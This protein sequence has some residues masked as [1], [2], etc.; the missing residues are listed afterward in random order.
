MSRTHTDKGSGNG[1][2]PAGIATELLRYCRSHD[3]AGYDP[4]DGLNSRVFQSLRFLHFK[5]PRLALIQ[6]LK[7]SPINFR[8]IL[9]VPQEQNPKGL[10]LF[11]TSLIKLS[12]LGLLRDDASIRYL[13][14]RLLSLSNSEN[15]YL[16]WGYHFDW[17]TRKV[18][19]PRGTP[20]IICTTFAANA[21]L[22]AHKH[23]PDSRFL[24]TVLG[25][26][27]FLLERLY[28]K[29]SDS[30][31]CFSY[32]QPNRTFVH[33]ANL[34]GAA[35]VSRV[36]RETANGSLLA[37][38]LEAAR[39]TVNKQ[40][41]DGSWDYGE[42]DHPSQRWIDNFHTG[43]NL[44]ALRAIGL[45]AESSEF[46]PAIRRGFDFFRRHFFEKDGA[47][48]YYHD[49]LYPIDI[50]SAAQSI[51]T[52]VTLKDLDSGNITL[53]NDVLAWTMSNMWNARGYF[54]FQKHR[55]WTN[56]IPY[57]RWS[58]AWMLLALAVLIE[59]REGGFPCVGMPVHQMRP[60]VAV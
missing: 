24:E 25:A 48:R 41:S 47:P 35:L 11:L 18:L 26:V 23:N 42:C 28:F 32:Y 55:W 15:G 37:P 4:Y 43:F 40:H 56:R 1:L 34:L 29:V 52:L 2:T 3:W 8:R 54:Y 19:V 49:R 46:E 14:E 51:I 9:M 10:A 12:K 45:H 50:H 31:S 20:N 39:F 60:V 53:A 57:M 30:E 58:Q 7:R 13:S 44:C 22:D 6:L 36:A 33:N 17:Q 21:L 5:Y 59:G 38:A 27:R 16:G